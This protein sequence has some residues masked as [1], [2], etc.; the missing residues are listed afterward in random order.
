M[1]HGVRLLRVSSAGWLAATLF[2]A[3]CSPDLA[4][5]RQASPLETGYQLPPKVIVDI[6]D[7]PPAPTVLVSPTRRLLALVDRPSMPKIADLAE[8]MLRLAGNRINPKTNGPHNPMTGVGLTLKTIADGTEIKVPLPAG[9]RIG[10]P[11]FS[12]DGTW[13][14]FFVYRTNG[15]ELW[16]ADAASGQPKALTS[17]TVNGLGICGWLNDSSAMLC[18]FTATGRGPAPTPPTVPVGPRIQE[19]VGNAA[20]VPTFQDMLTSAYDEALYQVLLHG[21]TRTGH[22]CRD[23]DAHR[24]AGP[25]RDRVDVAR[26]TGTSWSPAR[27]DRSPVS[28][29]TISSRRISRCGIER[30]TSC[31]G[32]AN[33]RSASRFPSAA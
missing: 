12:P 31:A 14:S 20:P 29:P 8:P 11:S 32:S 6:L 3:L 21:P 24:Q 23:T 13:L 1:T 19:S 5:A 22:A 2:V 18:E 25:V 33:S 7:A 10:L 4:L 16:I 9:V 15:I 26:R 17:A 27:S 30:V 28:F